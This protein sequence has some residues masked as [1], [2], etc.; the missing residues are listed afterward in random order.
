MESQASTD[1]SIS[2]YT[3]PS[4]DFWLSYPSTWV[5]EQ[6][7]GDGALLLASGRAARDR[8]V[9]GSPPTEGDLIV[10]VGFLPASLFQ[11]PQLRRFEIRVDAAPAEMLRSALQVF[12]LAANVELGSIE[13]VSLGE[14]PAGKGAVSGRDRE[15]LILTFAAGKGVAGIVSTICA[16]GETARFDEAVS[17]IVESVRFQGDEEALYGRLLTG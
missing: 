16:L 17:R 6:T 2:R 5:A 9:A 12:D 1:G 3:S 15:G 4:G 10:N 13:A 11:Q 14:R 7:L 8:Y